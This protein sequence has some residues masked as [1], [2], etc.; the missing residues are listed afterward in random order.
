MK[1]WSLQEG[2]TQ[3]GRGE[4]RKQTGQGRDL[5]GKRRNERGKVKEQRGK[6]GG[7]KGG[8]RCARNQ[9]V[10]EICNLTEGR[11][12][13]TQ[14]NDLSFLCTWGMFFFIVLFIPKSQRLL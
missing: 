10:A 14:E 11:S 7:K 5:R 13:K 2:R 12:L 9:M 1:G 3:E 4:Q 8:E 6:K